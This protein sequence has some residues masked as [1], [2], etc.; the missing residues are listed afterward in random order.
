MPVHH[1]KA[2]A[3][4]RRRR[5]D[6]G[7]ASRVGTDDGNF[8]RPSFEQHNT[9]RVDARRQKQHIGVVQ[10][11]VFPLP[12]RAEMPDKAFVRWIQ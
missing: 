4:R 7:D 8:V 9:E 11:R 10:Q 6:T 12:I 1:R 2:R 5:D 3:A